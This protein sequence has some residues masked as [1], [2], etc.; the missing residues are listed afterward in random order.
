MKMTF[1][2]AALTAAIA[3]PALAQTHHQRSSYA[4]QWNEAAPTQAFGQALHPGQRFVT[5]RRDIVVGGE[6]QGTDPDPII[7]EQLLR[8][9]PHGG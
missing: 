6:D 3:T 2:I 7:R 1:I 8:D 4:P 9:P 5:P